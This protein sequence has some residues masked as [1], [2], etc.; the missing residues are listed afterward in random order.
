[1]KAAG[2]VAGADDAEPGALVQGEAG[3]VLGK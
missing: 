1:V 3:G 2:T